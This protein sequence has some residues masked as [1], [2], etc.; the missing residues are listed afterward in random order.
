MFLHTW[1]ALTSSSR[2]IREPTVETTPDRTGGVVST[3]SVTAT[4][5][6]VVVS[7]EGTDA[8]VFASLST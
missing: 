5:A 4:D 1:V 7:T 3:N 2:P 6:A 8:T